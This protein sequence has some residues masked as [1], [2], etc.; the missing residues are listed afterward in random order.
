[1]EILS[2]PGLLS[3]LGFGVVVVVGGLLMA[4]VSFFS[5]K[6]TSFEDVMA[7]QKQKKEKEDK[8]R[9]RQN[10]QKREAY[11]SKLKRK[12]GSSSS[13]GSAQNG[14]VAAAE[15]Q[16]PL[17]EPSPQPAK[18]KKGKK[19]KAAAA[20][21]VSEPAKVKVEVE[22]EDVAP[23]AAAAPP[24]EEEAP[25][26]ITE[27]EIVAVQ[28]VQS[29]PE[30]Q[31]EEA[32]PEVAEPEVSSQNVLDVVKGATLSAADTKSLLEHL[33]GKKMPTEKDI[34]AL[35]KKNEG[36]ATQMQ[37]L[38]ADISAKDQQLS[39][40]NKKIESETASL[41]AAVA[42]KE[43]AEK[44]AADL[45]A[46]NAALTEQLAGKEAELKVQVENMK[47]Q[48]SQASAAALESK[49]VESLKTE[50]AILK[51]T[52]QDTAIQQS[53]RESQEK[54]KLTTEITALQEKLKDTN[55][56][57]AEMEEKLAE[58]QATHERQVEAE[59][60][61]TQRIEEMTAKLTEAKTLYSNLDSD[62]QKTQSDLQV[63]QNE[64]AK[65]LN[66]VVMLTEA[67]E[68]KQVLETE[69]ST[70]AETTKALEDRI[71]EMD[72]NDEK[73]AEEL[74]NLQMIKKELSE[75]IEQLKQANQ[76]TVT[77]LTEEIENLKNQNQSLQ[78][79]LAAAKTAAEEV[80]ALQTSLDQQKA[81]LATK[82][83]ELASTKSEL[84]TLTEAVKKA[85]E[86]S[87]ALKKKNNEEIESLKTLVKTSLASLE[88][89]PADDTFESFLSAAAEQ[90]TS[91][92]GS[93]V[94]EED[95]AAKDAELEKLKKNVESLQNTL[96][97]SLVRNKE[98]E[99]T[100]ANR[101]REI[102]EQQLMFSA[103]QKSLDGAHKRQ[104]EYEEKVQTRDSEIQDKNAEIQKFKSIMASTESILSDLQT[105]VELGE[106][107]KKAAQE[108]TSNLLSSAEDQIGEYKKQIESLHAELTQLTDSKAEVQK[109]LTASQDKCTELEA[110][111]VTH[112]KA[113]DHSEKRSSTSSASESPVHV[114]LA[115]TDDGGEVKVKDDEDV[116][117]FLIIEQENND[118]QDRLEKEKSLTKS[119]GEAAGRL[120]SV[121]KQT[122]DQLQK[123]K[124][125]NKELA[126]ANDDESELD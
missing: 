43:T 78:Q 36:L 52:L 44:S 56:S 118:L 31:P 37:S 35:K 3:V 41:K 64:S 47:V 109:Q 25:E 95:L 122:Q 18:T 40:L 16:T 83:V 32:Q 61:Y 85:E 74:A 55:K 100:I 77:K 7:R 93:K 89:S 114:D 70:L 98:S 107:Q 108:E 10:K 84:D 4:A 91:G 59:N 5:M 121:L 19:T 50:N 27:E 30:P 99:E 6:E 39:A 54:L 110:Q 125:K 86:D 63:N 126:K 104:K 22:V 68:Q 112:K 66:Q 80:S 97:G 72:A 2:D 24:A 94:S 48:M 17:V 53:A 106:Q 73:R 120:T 29:A 123:E 20:P 13:P 45:Q 62:F 58:F 103:L 46:A 1:M 113:S 71:A 15:E 69:C 14:S 111:V 38:S 92:S 42:G 76:E 82:D 57:K 49:E 102:E 79:D 87:E 119:L 28:E 67:N 9:S 117:G 51:S 105:Q 26:V 34:A 60:A 75:E 124:A 116:D 88:V 8:E 21:E 12:K 23:V 90:I 115:V 65:L 33:S 11:K 101:D 81:D 96:D